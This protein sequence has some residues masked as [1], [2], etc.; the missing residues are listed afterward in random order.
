MSN[1]LDQKTL[2]DAMREGMRQWASGVSIISAR[3]DQGEPQAMTASSLTSISDNPASLL[4][5]VNQNAR[6]AAV[7]QQGQR[8]CANVLAAE[9]ESLSNLCASPDAHEKRFESDEWLL[10]GTPR[11]TSALSTFEC[12]V[13]KVVTYG[14]HE[15]VIGKIIAVFTRDNEGSPLCYWNGGYRQLAL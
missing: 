3:D 15:V 8:F 7:L 14:T 5:C 12:E 1:N 11:I 13:D 6:M 4:V 10:E 9:H 2:A